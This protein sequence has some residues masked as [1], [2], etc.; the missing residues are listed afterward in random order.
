MNERKQFRV[1]RNTSK[2]FLPL[3]IATSTTGSNNS[4]IGKVGPKHSPLKSDKAILD[5][6]AK[7]VNFTK[8]LKKIC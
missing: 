7:E 1:E 2:P 8:C 4:R 5:E 3:R 6:S